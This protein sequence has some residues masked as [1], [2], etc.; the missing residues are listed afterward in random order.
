MIALVSGYSSENE[1]MWSLQ[2][3]FRQFFS[4]VVSKAIY[5]TKTKGLPDIPLPVIHT[6]I[7]LY[8][9][10]L[11]PKFHLGKHLKAPLKP[12]SVVCIVIS[13]QPKHLSIPKINGRIVIKDS[14]CYRNFTLLCLL[15]WILM[16][17]Y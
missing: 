6:Q 14:T 15:L 13:A 17:T 8:L 3:A 2:W 4:P 5:A 1:N 11:R 16:P 12:N 10:C 9:R 7:W